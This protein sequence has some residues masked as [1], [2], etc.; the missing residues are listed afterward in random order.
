M[1]GVIIVASIFIGI[2]GLAFYTG[3]IKIVAPENI[4]S[5]TNT[6]SNGFQFIEKVALDSGMVTENETIKKPQKSDAAN[7]QTIITSVVKKENS[8]SETVADAGISTTTTVDAGI[9]TTSTSEKDAPVISSETPPPILKH[10]ATLERGIPQISTSG[11][12]N[13]SEILAGV[14]G[15]TNY[16]FI[17]LYNPNEAVVDLTGWSIKKR[18]SSGSESVLVSANRFEG[19]KI[20]SKK[21]LL[22]ANEGG[23]NG[24]IQPDIV[25]PKSYSLAYKNNAIIFYNANGEAIEDIGWDEIA[26]GQSLERVSWES[27]EFKIQNNPNPQNSQN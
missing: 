19:R 3:F 4:F 11:H 20:M 10:E 2:I 6:A 27:D 24:V 16:E 17:E 18:S 23:Y 9:A 8:S 1:K 21:Y 15:N 14:D 7:S 22:L 25:W 5:R 12:I 13:V 26:K